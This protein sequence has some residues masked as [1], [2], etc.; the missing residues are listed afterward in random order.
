MVRDI[1]LER[2]RQE[3]LPLIIHHL[4]PE[5][6]LVFGSRARGTA[7]EE[8]DIDIIIISKRFG[9]IPFIRRMPM[10]M[11]LIPF[12]KHIDY[13]CYPPEEFGR[14]KDASSIIIDA[15]NEPLELAVS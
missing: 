15:L 5:R 7:N 1:W 12:P 4:Q 10:M 8:S 13:L 6:V 2:F 3:A 9:E 11:K 14:M